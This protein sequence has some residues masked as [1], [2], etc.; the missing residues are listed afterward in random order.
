MLLTTQILIT[1]A[2]VGYC[3][4]PTIFDMN[5][6]HATNPTWTGHAR[7]HV[8]WQVSSYD[9]IALIGLY[10]T[11]TADAGGDGLWIPALIAL[12]TYGGFWIAWATQALYGGVLQDAVNGVPDVHYDILGKRFAVDANVSL[13]LPLFL[14][15]VAAVVFAFSLGDP[16]VA[17]H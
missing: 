12:A 14:L 16:G 11:W 15:N 7:Y 1:V 4:I 17:G 9:L 10:L 2:T 5:K 6:S 13:F 3:V 8:V